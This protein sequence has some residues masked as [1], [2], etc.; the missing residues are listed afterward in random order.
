MNIRIARLDDAKRLLDIY[1]Y[2]VTNTAVSF[3]YEIPSEEDFC[4]RIENTLKKY[5]YLVA[6]EDG[7]I[8]GYTYAS[9]FHSRKAYLY[10]A[11]LSIYVD[12]EYRGKGIGKRL[13]R[14]IQDI[15]IKQN[16]LT[17]YACIAETE[18]NEDLYLTDASIKFH[19]QDGFEITGRHVR[20]GLKFGRWYNIVWMEKVIH[21]SFDAPED[22]I[23]FSDLPNE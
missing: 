17:A 22:F 1:G 15:L 9:Q 3:E 20:S 2:Y 10:G 4:G 6:E 19:L 21:D 16:V 13:Y 23:P 5:P 12:R 7:K 8:V 14:E 18:N 11:E